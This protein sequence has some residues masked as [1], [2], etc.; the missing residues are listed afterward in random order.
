[1]NR[2]TILTLCSVVLSAA[3]FFYK[4][5]IPT[6]IAAGRGLVIKKDW[7]AINKN[8]LTPKEFVRPADQ[9]F[10]TFPEWYLV[11]SPDEQATYFKNHT[12]SSF[13]Y[14]SHVKQFWQS[15]KIIN[16]QI[17]D[18][19]PYNTG[20]HFMIWVIGTSTTVEYTLKALYETTIG[21]LT[22]TYAVLTEED[23]FTTKF[24]QDYVD[25]IKDRP[26]YEFD[27][28]TRLVSLWS[29][30]SFFGEHFFRKLDRKYILSSELIVK[31][32]Y[33]KLIGLGTK[34]V[35][36]AALP[37]TEVLVDAIPQNNLMLKII[38]EYPDKS[39]L[40]SLPRYDKFNQAISELAING[41]T[42]KEIAGN[43]SA[44]L[45]SVLVPSSNNFNL[46][47]VQTVFKQPVATDPTMQ[48]I[49]VAVPVKDL[50]KLFIKLN[51]DKVK[52]EHIFDF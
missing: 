10:L 19:F 35:Y 30:T 13:P 2:L 3:I 6:T 21:R 17:K 16:Q 50:N 24:T 43:N 31:F 15:Y 11:F 7:L 25:F 29:T 51:H 48:R 47:Y 9:T 38:K 5:R 4:K 1:M 18:N 46:D 14:M 33:G 8:P 45:L 22:D 26:W 20:Y 34:T 36:D 44:I 32:L 49:A 42:F 39:A 12:S 37:T 52:I 23:I 27:F 28:K 41:F 40:I